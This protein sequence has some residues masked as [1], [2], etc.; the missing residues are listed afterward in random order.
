ML[1]YNYYNLLIVL[2]QTRFRP[3]I[4]EGDNNVTRK[5]KWMLGCFLFLLFLN[6]FG[7]LAVTILG[8]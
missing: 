8:K 2:K 6:G 5:W 1:N 3:N 4:F 7:I